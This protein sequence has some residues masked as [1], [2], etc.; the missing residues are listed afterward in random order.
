[1]KTT[2]VDRGWIRE[3]CRTA[4]DWHR[5]IT[6]DEV[7]C[8]CD[9]ADMCAE[10]SNKLGIRTRDYIGAQ[11]RISELE[12]EVTRLMEGMQSI[13]DNGPACLQGAIRA[14]LDGDS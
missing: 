8:L 12:A 10:L 2:K 14:L 1:M 13:S 6:A 9:D 7:E 4:P 11:E 3:K 5:F